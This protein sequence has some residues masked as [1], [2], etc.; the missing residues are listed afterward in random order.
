MPDQPEGPPLTGAAIGSHDY[1]GLRFASIAYRTA[2][3]RPV[4]FY[5]VV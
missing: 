1:L 2:H 4:L 5:T 3:T